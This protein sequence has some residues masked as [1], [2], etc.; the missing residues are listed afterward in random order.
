MRCMCGSEPLIFA[1]QFGER[2]EVGAE[3]VR[4]LVAH[5]QNRSSDSEAGGVLVGRR[6]S[7]GGIVLDRAFGPNSE[8]SRSRFAFGRKRAPAQA[9][10]DS[11]WKESGGIAHYL[12]EWHTHPQS[13]PIPSLI[14]KADWLRISTFAKYNG[15]GL[16]FLIMGLDGLGAWSVQRG[17]LRV[18]ELVRLRRAK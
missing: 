11:V 16:I 2:I 4:H 9:Q 15:A 8:D 14:D 18:N 13:V 1:D 5:R 6:L 10:V 3:V 7:T 12:G 17:S